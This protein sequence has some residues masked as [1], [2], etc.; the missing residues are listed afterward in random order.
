METGFER[1]IK[2]FC[3]FEGRWWI[4]WRTHNC[5]KHAAKHQ[6]ALLQ[7]GVGIWLSMWVV[8]AFKCQYAVNHICINTETKGKSHFST[9]LWGNAWACF[10]Q[11]SDECR[12][13]STDL[14]LTCF[15]PPFS[16][17]LIHLFIFCY[18][19]A[20][21][22]PWRQPRHT[23]NAFMRVSPLRWITWKSD[24]PQCKNLFGAQ[25]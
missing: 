14:P 11:H 16:F 12:R 7:F 9:F 24:L 21:P 15:P 13:L 19:Y 2:C 18:R 5:I 3:P 20:C 1:L 6:R 23:R 25:L 4:W 10:G 17:L 22:S 8:T